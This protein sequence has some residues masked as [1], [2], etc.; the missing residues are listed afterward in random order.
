MRQLRADF[1]GALHHVYN[2][3]LDGRDIFVDDADRLLPAAVTFYS[4]ERNSSSEWKVWDGGATRRR[5]GG[6]EPTF[7]DVPPILLERF[8]GRGDSLP[9]A[10]LAKGLERRRIKVPP[11]GDDTFDFSDIA[12]IAERIL[13]EQDEVRPHAG[14][15][16]T[17]F[18]LQP[19]E[20]GGVQN[21]CLKRLERG[22]PDS[23]Y[24]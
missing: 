17:D 24:E 19:E 11:A 10:A 3:G 15:D 8:R 6:S 23:I 4:S 18:F 13:P 16:E 2:R 9:L 20:A 1:A 22:K 14:G 12:D 21:G 7:E 5:G